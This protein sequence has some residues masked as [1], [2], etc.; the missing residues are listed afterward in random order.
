MWSLLIG[1]LHNYLDH[2]D[3]AAVNPLLRHDGHHMNNNSLDDGPVA[4][5]TTVIPN[6]PTSLCWWAL[7]RI[8]V[9]LQYDYHGVYHSPEVCMCHYCY[10][11]YIC[12]C[13]FVCVYPPLGY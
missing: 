12:V 8:V 10:C 11:A 9:L 13:A 6:Q 7:Y 4:M 1:Y 2:H 5:A 3:N